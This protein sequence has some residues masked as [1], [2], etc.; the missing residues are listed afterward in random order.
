[1]PPP[2][3]LLTIRTALVLLA[4]LVIGLIAGAL[5][6]AA[7][8]DLPTAALVAGS[9]AGGGLALIHSILEHR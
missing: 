7:Y 5:A 6:F 8:G 2:R 4:A 3:P 1:M 9:A